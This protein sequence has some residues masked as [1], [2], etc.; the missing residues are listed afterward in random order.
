MVVEIPARLKP[1][2][3]TP[4]LIDR[5]D[6]L[7]GASTLRVDRAGNRHAVMFKWPPMFGRDRPVHTLLARLK[8]A[9]TRGIRMYLPL[10][11]PQPEAGLPVVDGAGQSGT[12]LSVRGLR[13]SYVAREDFWFTVV[14]ADGRGYLHSLA[15]TSVADQS[16][17]ATWEIE[18][19]LRK[20]FAD[21][22]TIH[23]AQPFIEGFIDGRELPHEIPG[24]KWI[25]LSVTVEE[26]R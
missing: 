12:T 18:P 17:Q 8:R 20:P 25:E 6:F 15:E 11:I 10:L 14:D 7:R 1:N 4:T 3:M 13:A 26:Y 5:G 2:S 23:I 9:K 24:N 22:A 21:G 19:A 16:G